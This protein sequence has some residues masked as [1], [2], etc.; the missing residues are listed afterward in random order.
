MKKY[1]TLLQTRNKIAE[2][3]FT[4]GYQHLYNLV[5]KGLIVPDAMIESQSISYYCFLSDS[6]QSIIDYV[7]QTRSPIKKDKRYYTKW[8]KEYRESKKKTD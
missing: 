5:R 8:V 7:K 1:Y 4:I 6:F 3:G 2:T